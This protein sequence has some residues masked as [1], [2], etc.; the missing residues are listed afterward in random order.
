MGDHVEELESQVARLIG[1][2]SV[3]DEQM[4][5]VILISSLSGSE[6]YAATLILVNSMAKDLATWSHDTKILLEG[7]RRQARNE[8]ANERIADSSDKGS[9]A[10]SSSR[11]QAA[12]EERSRYIRR[13]NEDHTGHKA[14]QCPPCRSPT[15]KK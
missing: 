11:S 13:Y 4:R 10:S 5:D 2:C 12:K 8:K 15:S 3:I 9:T 1:M 7:S 14:I 6:D